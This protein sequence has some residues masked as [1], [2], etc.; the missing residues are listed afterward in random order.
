MTEDWIPDLARSSGA[1]YLAIADALTAAIDSGVLSGG[2]RLPPQRDLAARLGVD[3]TTIT[4]AYDV[5]RQR[6]LIEARGRVGSFVRGAA[7]AET[8]DI[9]R[10]DTGMNMPPELPGDML[11][12]AMRDTMTLLLE[13]E[14]V[15][16][17]QYQPAGGGGADRAAGARLIARWGIATS[18]D[19]VVVAAGAQNA[20]HA[21]LRA[22]LERGDAIACGAFVYSGFKAL[23]AGL[24]LTLVPLASVDGDALDAACR[25]QKIRALYVVPTNDNPTTSTLDLATRR[26]VADQARLHGLLIIEDDVYRPLCSAPPPPVATLAPERTWYVSSVSKTISPALRIAYVHAPDV[27]EALRIAGDV[28]ETA[29]MAPPLNAALVR[30]WLDDGR[31]DLLVAAMR[32]EATRRQALAADILGGLPYRAHPEGYHLWLPLPPE[33][34]AADLVHTMYPS[35]LSVVAGDRFR[36]GPGD[37]QAVRV[38]LGGLIDTPRLTRALHLLRGLIDTRQ[39]RPVV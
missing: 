33:I 8:E 1:K 2:D 30:T 15:L 19:Q 20:L 11:G 26:A 16:R 18:Q 36:V 28:H 5:A 7:S 17:L 12:R 29:I 3:L 38:S 6:G 32:R 24:G 14:S 27:G 37:N 10:I 35:G 9:A 39:H 4:K 31:H 13:E 25:T 23:A 21:I 34:E 22:N